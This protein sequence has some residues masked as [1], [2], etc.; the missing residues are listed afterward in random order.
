MLCENTCRSRFGNDGQQYI[1]NSLCQDGDDGAIGAQCDLGTDCADCG[2]RNYLPPSPPP[3]SPLPSPP[4]PSPPPMQCSDDCLAHASGPGG[5]YASNGHC[6][7]G[8]DD[9]IS[10]TCAFGTDCTDCGP[11]YKSPPPSPPSA[12]PVLCENTCLNSF[13]EGGQQ[14][15][16]NSHCQDGHAGAEDCILERAMLARSPK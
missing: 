2:P 5:P 15:I 16:N 3:P 9:A 10:D 4:P 8:E 11:R 6:Q 1:N 7:D 12:P 14:Y 13:G